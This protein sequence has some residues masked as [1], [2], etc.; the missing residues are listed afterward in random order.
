MFKDETVNKILGDG[1]VI[2][3][4]LS[5]LLIDEDPVSIFVTE[6]KLVEDAILVEDANVESDGLFDLE[7]DDVVLDDTLGEGLIV[8]VPTGVLVTEGNI[9]GDTVK[10]SCEVLLYVG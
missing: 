2:T 5:E 4:T 8:V 3:E 7:S 1:V 6:G 9:E 10:D